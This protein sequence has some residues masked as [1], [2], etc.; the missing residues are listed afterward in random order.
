VGKWQRLNLGSTFTHPPVDVWAVL[1]LVPKTGL[2]TDIRYDIGY[3]QP[4]SR[5]GRKL[6][7]HGTR[8]C[9][10]P[11]KMKRDHDI[12]WCLVPPFNAV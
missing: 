4:D 5:T 7:W 9:E 1:R 10:D 11:A 8:G 12:W 3:L 2:H 6:W